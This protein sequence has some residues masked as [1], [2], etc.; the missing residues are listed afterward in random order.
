MFSAKMGRASALFYCHIY[1]VTR[2]AGP[3]KLANLHSTG[4][5]GIGVAGQPYLPGFIK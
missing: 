1:V 5:R 2:M 3:R 4:S